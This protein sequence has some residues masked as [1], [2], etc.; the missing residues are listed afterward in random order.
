MNVIILTYKVNIFL[1]IHEAKDLKK[2]RDQKTD[3]YKRM[4]K[5]WLYLASEYIANKYQN[6]QFVSIL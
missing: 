4:L 2:I 6:Q 5:K 1:E 3:C